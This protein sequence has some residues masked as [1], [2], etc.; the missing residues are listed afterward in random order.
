MRL[1]VC[2]V[3]G[4]YALLSAFAAAVQWRQGARRDTPIAMLCGGAMLLAAGKTISEVYHAK[5]CRP[6][7]ENGGGV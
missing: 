3:A 7:R 1:L 6:A 5:S 2:T 4:A